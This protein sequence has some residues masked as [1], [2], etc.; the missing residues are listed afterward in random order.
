MKVLFSLL[1]SLPLLQACNQLLTY[2]IDVQL[3]DRVLA[4]SGTTYC[5]HQ[6]ILPVGIGSVHSYSAT[7][8]YAFLNQNGQQWIL[9]GIDCAA[10][11]DGRPLESIRLFKQKNDKDA[12]LFFV[13]KDGPIKVTRTSFDWRATIGSHKVQTPPRY[14]AGPYRFQKTFLKELPPS[15]DTLLASRQHTTVVRSYISLQCRGPDGSEPV[16]DADLFAQLRAELGGRVIRSETGILAMDSSARTWELRTDRSPYGPL[17]VTTWEPDSESMRSHDPMLSKCL[18][19]SI[20]GATVTLHALAGS[21]LVYIPSEKAIFTLQP[22]RNPY[23]LSRGAKS[24][25]ELWGY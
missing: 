4:F 13:T 15:L 18:T 1:L 14:N 20:A 19:I 12:E 9:E 23:Q 3:E 6:F 5:R 22:L 25:V 2:E 7:D 16:L 21:A 10:A 24:E 17:D 8:R 11:M